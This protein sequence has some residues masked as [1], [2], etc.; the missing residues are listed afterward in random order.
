MRGNQSQRRTPPFWR[1]MW[2]WLVV[3]LAG[4][5]PP[6]VMAEPD[7]EEPRAISPEA[8]VLRDI[9]QGY[10]SNARPV[11]HGHDSVVISFEFRLASL[12]ELVRSWNWARTDFSRQFHQFSLSCP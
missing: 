7:D 10:H 3:S 2:A 1:L 11:A 9:L 8:A 12:E 4:V 6:A 5:L